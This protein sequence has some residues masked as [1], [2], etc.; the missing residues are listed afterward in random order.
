MDFAI[1]RGGT[2]P[3]SRRGSSG[4]YEPIADAARE[5]PGEWISVA[6]LSPNLSGSINAGKTKGFEST[7]GGHYEALSR[8]I[9]DGKCTLWVRFINENGADA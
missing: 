4:K 5:T 7:P 9:K 1:K 8:N 6:G 3:A 2:P